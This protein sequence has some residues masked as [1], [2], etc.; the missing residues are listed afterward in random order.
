M[1]NPM[2]VFVSKASLDHLTPVYHRLNED[3]NDHDK[4]MVCNDR[5]HESECLRMPL[6]HAGRF[7][8]PCLNCY[9]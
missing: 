2:T 6:R 5:L 9:S 1:D 4:T 8:D 7:A 3:S